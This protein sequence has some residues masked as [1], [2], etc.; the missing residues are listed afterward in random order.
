MSKAADSSPITGP[1]ET[2]VKGPSQRSWVAIGAAVVG[3][4]LAVVGFYATI[5]A[6]LD[7]SGSGPTVS[8]VVMLVGL[9]LNLVAIVL[10]IVTL[11]RDKKR[12][13]PWVAIAIAL[14]PV[15]TFVWLVISVRL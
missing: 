1:I 9:V 7:G 4:V 10:A 11:V 3:S 15:I 6:A 12:R 5:I 8:L 2:I 13:L 14:V